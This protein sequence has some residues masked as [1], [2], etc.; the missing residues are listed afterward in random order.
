MSS[1]ITATN[2]SAEANPVDEDVLAATATQIRKLRR[3]LQEAG[4][5]TVQAAQRKCLS[6]AIDLVQSIKNS[7]GPGSDCSL[8]GRWPPPSSRWSG[9]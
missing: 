2:E 5:S 4:G 7:R 9:N 1:A 6:E 3:L 8:Y